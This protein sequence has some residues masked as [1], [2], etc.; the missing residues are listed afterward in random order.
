MNHKISRVEKYFAYNNYIL[1]RKMHIFLY[2]N[3][4]YNKIYFFRLNWKFELK[5]KISKILIWIFFLSI[6]E[7]YDKMTWIVRSVWILI[8]MQKLKKLFMWNNF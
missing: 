6:I 8:Y 5:I 4:K 2:Q 3:L 1:Q 7:I